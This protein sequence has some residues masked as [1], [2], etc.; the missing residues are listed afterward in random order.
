M[1]GV[2]S[3]SIDGDNSTWTNNNGLTVGN[4]GTGTLTLSN[5]GKA[6]AATAFLAKSPGSIGTINIGAAPNATAEVPGTLQ[7]PA[8]T[9]GNGTGTLNFNHTG[10]AYEFAPQVS[11]GGAITLVAGKTILT[12]DPSGFT[13]TTTIDAGAKLQFG[14]D[15]GT[16]APDLTYAGILAGAGTMEVLANTVRLTG[17]SFGFEGTARI[18]SHRTLK[19]ATSGSFGGTVHADGLFRY[20]STATSSLTFEGAGS[21]AVDSGRIIAVKNSSGFTGTATVAHGAVLQVAATGGTAVFGGAIGGAGLLDVVATG[22]GTLT[23]DASGFA[24]TVTIARGGTLRIGNGGRSGL[25]GGAVTN[26][27][28]LAFDRADASS[29]AGT[30]AGSGTIT[31]RGGIVLMTGDASAFAGETTVDAG[32][33]LRIDDGGTSGRL[34]G[35]I[36]NSGTLTFGRIDSITAANVISG[37]G[38]SNCAS[39]R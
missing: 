20:A 6:T 24:G 15:T 34:G 5:G 39:E 27:G 28:T 23:G 21:L 29:F 11:G 12:A 19:V 13:G 18:D 9:F 16:T 8:L 25:L 38:P 30:L 33:T 2:G 7:V 37:G 17:A 26:D 32:A 22:T 31:T 14:N 35:R 3:A 1:T 36:A 10:D 4:L